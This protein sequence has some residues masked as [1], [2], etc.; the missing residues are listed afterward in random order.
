MSSVTAQRL[1]ELS[2]KQRQLLALLKKEKRSRKQVQSHERIVRR[3]PSD[4]AVLSFAQQRLWLIDQLDPGTPAFNIPAAVRLQ[5]RLDLAVLQR[6]FQEIVDRH[7]SLRTSFGLRDGQPI[8]RIMPRVGFELKRTDLERLDEATQEELIQRLATVFCQVSFCLEEAPLLRGMLLRL[9]EDD[10]VVLLSLHHIVGDV[11]SIRVLLRELAPLYA[12]FLAGELSPLAEPPIQYADYAVWQREWLSAERLEK[13]LSFWRRRLADAP[14]V[15]EV[16]ADRPRPATQS[17]WGA[18]YFIVLSEALVAKTRALGSQEDASL[19]MTFLAVWRSLLFRYTGRE[20]LIIGSPVANRTRSE[21]EG[22]IGFFVNSLVLRTRVDGNASWRELLRREREATLEAFNYQDLPFEKLV[23]M[24]QPERDMSRHPVFQVDFVLQNSPKSRVETPG[25]TLTPLEVLN[26]TAQVDLTL[27]L[28]E[29]EAGVRGWLQY[30]SDLFEHSTVARLAR[31]FETL[32]AAVVQAPDQPLVKHSLL[33]PSEIQQMLVEWNDTQRVYPDAGWSLIELIENQVDRSPDSIAVRFEDADL[34][35]LELDRRASQLARHL[36]SLNV[37]PGKRVA[38]ALDRSLELMVALVAILKAGGAYVPLDPSY[39]EERLAFM[40]EDSQVTVLLSQKKYR[41]GVLGALTESVTPVVAIDADW[42]EVAHRPSIRLPS[43]AISTSPAYMIYTSGS[44]GRPKGAVVS[45]AAIVNRLLWMQGAYRLEPRDRVLQKTPVSFDVSVW[46]LFWPLMTGAC[47]VMARPGGHQDPTYLTRRI[48]EDGITVLHFVPSMLRAFLAEPDVRMCVSLRQV[49][50]S[51][52][53]LALD[54]QEL[55]FSQLDVALDNLYGPTEAAVDVTAWA[56]ERDGRRRIVPIGR[57]IANIALQ[58]LDRTNQLVPLGAVGEL[59]LAGCGLGQGYRGRPGLSAEKFVPHPYAT[60]EMSGA[61]FYRTGDLARYASD[62]CVEF[63]GRID[64]Q[65]KVRGFRIELGEIESALGRCPGI[66]ETVVVTRG[67]ESQARLVAYLVANQDPPPEIAGLRTALAAELPEYMV[68]GTFVF[69]PALPRHP[70]GKLDRRGLPAPE[71]GGDGARPYIAPRTATEEALAGIWSEV[72]AY[73]RVGAADHFFERGGHSLLG[74][75]VVSRIRDGMQVTVSLQTLFQKPVLEDLAAFLDVARNGGGSATEE[76]APILAVSRRQPLPL[77]FAQERMWFIHQ[78]T[79]DVSAY[80]IPGAVR[81]TGRLEV[82]LLEATFNQMI[83]R[84]EVL[85]TTFSQPDGQPVQIIHRHQPLT[86]RQVDLQHLSDVREDTAI[87]LA[88]HEARRTFDLEHGPLMRTVLIRLGECHHLL[89]VTIHHIVYDMWSREIFLRELSVLYGALAAGQP[90]LLPEL[91]IQYADFAAWQRQWLQG[92]VLETQLDFWKRQLA[93]K[94][95]V[96]EMPTDRPRSQLTTFAGSR[97]FFELS[98]RHT[99]ALQKLSNQQGATLFI[100]LLS[101]FDVL[102][103]RVTGQRDLLVGSP[104]ANRNRSE[105]ESL[106]G[107]FSNTLVLRSKVKRDMSFSQLLEA[108]RE[109]A[110]AAYDHQDLPFER[111]VGELQEARDPNRHPLVQVLFNFLP[112]YKP[113]KMTLGD[114]TLEPEWVHAGALAFDYMLSLWESDGRLQGSLDFSAELFDATTM[115]RFLSHYQN[116]LE[117]VLTCGDEAVAGLAML[118]SAEHHQLLREWNTAPR[119]RAWEASGLH[120]IFEAQVER[121][122][123]GV[124]VV[125]GS[126]ELTYDSLNNRANRLA[127]SLRRRGVGPGTLVGLA[128]E[129]SLE[130]VVGVLGILKAGGAYLPLDPSYPSDRLGFMLEDARVRWVVTTRGGVESLPSEMPDGVG[131]VV[132][133][134]AES[135]LPAQ[136][137]TGNLDLE[138]DIASPAYVIYTSGSTGRPKGTR[139]AHRNV[140]RL[141]EGTRDV[142]GFD[143]RDV[144]TLFHS[145]AFDFSVWELWGALLYG[146]RLV[147]VPY[148]VSRSPAAFYELLVCQQVTVLNHTPSAFRQLLQHEEELAVGLPELAVRWVIFG[149]EALEL[150]SLGPWFERHDAAAKLINMYGITETTVHV[151]QQP[152]LAEATRNPGGSS[153]GRPLP[154]Y[155]VHVVDVAAELVPVGTPGEMWVGGSGLAE[156]YLGRPGLTA[157]KFIPDPFGA[158]AGD[159]LYRSGDQA[160]LTA[161]GRMDYLGRIDQQIKVRGFRIEP[162]EIETVLNGFPGL[163]DCAVIVRQDKTGSPHLAAFVV[164]SGNA[165]PSVEELHTFLRHELP[166]YMIPSALVT[167]ESLPINHNGKVD[168]AALRQME[169]EKL[170]SEAPFLAPRTPLEEELVEIWRGLLAVEQVG[171]Q[172][173]FFDL[174][175]HSLLTTQLI[176]RLRNAFQI[177][178][179]LQTFF[180]DPTVAGLAQTIELARWADEVAQDQAEGEPEDDLEEGEF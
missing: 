70:N 161:G 179:S 165:K 122:P 52:E 17:P 133:L 116:L 125:C 31:H 93:N 113:P 80:N 102:L 5:G 43:V 68:P 107:Y 35:Y 53:A 7:E 94:P 173:S 135:D 123:S 92:E 97:I 163:R 57:P 40:L 169:G 140:M 114:L 69:L 166:D 145:F 148:T 2:P 99:R 156:G 77:A 8:Q 167:L 104:I 150:A 85:R 141:F 56:C 13:H 12:A 106:M 34:T 81:L 47:L 147:V 30:D 61:R 20:D 3:Q 159:R 101:V 32:L 51:G 65:V 45:H 109:M 16:P 22:M 37:G 86:L 172:D 168:R 139:I 39:P 108:N 175:G 42:H 118:T 103:Y 111:L 100:T 87:A 153:I 75:Q 158:T 171:V 33:S 19:Y 129:R 89:V 83:Q 162:E 59:H 29:V 164:A 79:P 149:G 44:T 73:P 96:L 124:A 90:A 38:V 66:A 78:L 82:P 11:W 62:G 10:H 157:E 14:L 142:Y 27:D 120:R 74:T 36:A 151:T 1:A 91:P 127:H 49:I 26:G 54:L 98:V 115:V 21:L 152:I 84:H 121:C 6:S 76:A 177:E 126:D 178:V 143:D 134:D 46:E 41:G 130:L 174:G 144:W 154:G 48:R 170:H 105:V 180:E 88:R 58:V 119:S 60:K 23:E 131:E 117:S 9:K 137:A 63:L 95:A 110:L 67:R 24:L 28:W 55:F 176:S 128:I 146:G 160:R 15:L 71:S 132:L 18:K 112:N 155:R 25:L 136:P 64:H 72:L 50:V 4:T 138:I